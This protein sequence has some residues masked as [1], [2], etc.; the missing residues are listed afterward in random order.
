MR[1]I[2]Y[3]LAYV[4]TAVVLLGLDIVWLS[5]AGTWLYRPL[6]G[7]ILRPDFDPV[8]A[9]LFYLIYVAGIVVFVIAPSLPQA[10]WRR[11]AV[12]GAFFGV[13]AYGSYDLTNQATLV[14]WP[15]IVTIPDL[16][17]GAFLTATAATLAHAAVVRIARPGR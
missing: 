14:H 16:C 15:V 9:V 7:P 4:V 12:R 5:L 6:L 8:A 10:G 2:T 11:V 1:V 3:G 17:W 13:V